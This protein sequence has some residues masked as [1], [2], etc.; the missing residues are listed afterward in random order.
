MS[1]ALLFF[2]EKTLLVQN[3]K[4][5]EHLVEPYKIDAHSRF[6]EDRIVHLIQTNVIQ[7]GF[8]LEEIYIDSS[9]GILIPGDIYDTKQ[10]EAYFQLNY[11]DLDETKS[12]VDD[13]MDSMN[14]YFI[15]TRI[16][17][18]ESFCRTHFPQT[19]LSNSSKKYLD[20]VAHAKKS[21]SEVHLVLKEGSFDLIKYSNQKLLSF[22]TIAYDTVTDVI[23]FLLAHLNKL[24]NPAKSIDLFGSES[25]TK[26]AHEFF[27]K[28]EVLKKIELNIFSQKERIK[29]LS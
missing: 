6:V 7:K 15:S 8:D 12:V 27:N 13:K 22:N 20:T 29:L 3:K 21:N 16:K 18:F 1:S 9:E 14:A 23:Y 5:G 17:W 10:K 25:Q 19:Q 26:E 28:I 2:N 24:K 11:T 4:S